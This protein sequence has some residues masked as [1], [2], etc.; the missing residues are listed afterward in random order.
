MIFGSPHSGGNCARLLD[1]VLAVFGAENCN[2]FSPFQAAP[3]FCDDCGWCKAHTE[4]KHRDLDEFYA[5]L[6]VCRVLVMVCPVYNAGFPAPVKAALDRL[7]RYY[8]ARFFQNI[9]PPVKTVKLAL[10][11]FAAGQNGEKA[12]EY[13]NAALG[14][15]YT[16]LNCRPASSV[17]ASNT[18]KFG[19]SNEEVEKVRQECL[20]IKS[21]M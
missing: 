5:A 19:V 18:D 17:T 2:I 11:L 14:K 16:V 7:Q 9:R 10:T 6:E 21:V 20:K 8:S 12:A 15:I 13:M 1:P 3:R 4:C